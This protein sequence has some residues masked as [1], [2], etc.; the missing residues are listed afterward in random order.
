[1]SEARVVTR[2]WVLDAMPPASRIPL[3][4]GARRRVSGPETSERL[5]RMMW[6]LTLSSLSSS[7]SSSFV[8]LFSQ[9]E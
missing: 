6:G 1:V 8:F 5:G 7:S 3:A 9:K 4:S 2:G